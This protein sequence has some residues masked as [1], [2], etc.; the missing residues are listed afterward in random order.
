MDVLLTGYGDLLRFSFE[1]LDVVIDVEHVLIQFG[2]V[3][4]L[5]AQTDTSLISAAGVSDLIRHVLE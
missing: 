1:V 4:K 5:K 3:M 2:K